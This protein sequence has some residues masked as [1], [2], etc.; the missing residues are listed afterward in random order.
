MSTRNK[1]LIGAALIVIF[2]IIGAFFVFSYFRSN[3]N[4]TAPVE[5][6]PTG[7]VSQTVEDPE[8]TDSSITSSNEN[9]GAEVNNQDLSDT[10]E[11]TQEM[12]KVIEEYE[13]DLN[14]TEVIDQL[15]ATYPSDLIPIYKATNAA[16]S[17]DIIT[18]NGRPG[19]TAT[20][21]SDASVTE[22]KTFYDNLMKSTSGYQN[23]QTGETFYISGTVDNCSVQISVSPNNPQQTGLNDK[24]NVSIF[25][26]RN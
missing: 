12:Q 14:N 24:T 18:D 26:E 3:S 13:P 1:Y 4:Q 9:V 17:N 11:P 15:A 5:Y 22:I 20:Y 8:V 6:T 2:I 19:W 10:L 25:I 21:G 16:D 7:Q 23:E